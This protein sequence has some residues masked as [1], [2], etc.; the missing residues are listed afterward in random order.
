MKILTLFFIAFISFVVLPYNS[1]SAKDTL[2]PN[3]VCMFCPCC[4][5][6]HM[7]AYVVDMPQNSSRSNL[8]TI[9]FDTA[10]S[11]NYKFSYDDFIPGEDSI[12]H[13]DAYVLNQ[14]NNARIVLTF[15]DFAGNDTT[16]QNDFYAQKLTVP[17]NLDFG[18][19][20]KV[21]PKEMIY[22]IKN[23]SNKGTLVL[24]SIALMYKNNGFELKGFKLPYSLKPLDSVAITVKALGIYDGVFIDSIGVKDTCNLFRYF[25]QIKAKFGSPRIDVSDWNFGDVS[26]GQTANGTIQVRNIGTT[27]LI[28][29]GYT[30]P[31]L[32]GIFLAPDLQVISVA[33]P[34]TLAPNQTFTYDVLFIPP[35]T[36][37]YLD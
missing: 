26:V 30:N 25:S 10:K 28:I 15:T 13:W 33:N 18:I 27:D 24:D 29:T 14:R 2:P 4:G 22:W 23:S 34:L 31:K 3:P 20:P 12:T 1:Y 7:N 19:L 32:T 6:I 21:E 5:G 35:D 9:V 16:I 37:T 8:G 17:S 36:L 11:F